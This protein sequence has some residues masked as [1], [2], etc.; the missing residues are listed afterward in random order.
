MDVDQRQQ[1]GLG[2]SGGGPAPL[3]LEQWSPVGED[4]VR[5]QPACQEGLAGGGGLQPLLGD[6]AIQG[7]AAFDI[8]HHAKMRQAV[9]GWM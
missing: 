8:V 2:C 9:D 7:K 3:R 1:Q 6:A 5:V 4:R